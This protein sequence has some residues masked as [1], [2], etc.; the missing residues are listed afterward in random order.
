[1]RLRDQI[2]QLTFVA[3]DVAMTL[4]GLLSDFGLKDSYVA[5]MKAA[6]LTISPSTTIVDISHSIERYDV[7]QGMFVLAS[8]APYFPEESILLAVVDPGVGGSRR[9]LLLETRRSKFVGPDNGLLS[10]AAEKEGVTAA[11]HLNESKYFADKVSPTFHGRDVFAHAVGHL[12]NDVPAFK[13]GPRITD[14]VRSTISEARLHDDEIH[15]RV[16]HIDHFGNVV[17]D[18]DFELLES[19]RIDFG[20]RIRIRASSG[21]M[22]MQFCETYS[23]VSSG[24]L[25]ATIGSQ[26]FLELAVNQGDAARALGA[27]VGDIILLQR[28]ALS[29]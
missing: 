28:V 17:T 20:A 16:L 27:R 8:V 10:P 3:R 29:D 19:G 2:D 25:L 1:M 9:P 12:A 26:G 18:I 22:E 6:I 24:Q 4:V 13:M 11:Y 7:R 5:Q 21:D 15:G 23:D 14:Y